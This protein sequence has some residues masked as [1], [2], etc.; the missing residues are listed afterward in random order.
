MSPSS[1]I[2]IAV[3]L[4]LSGPGVRVFRERRFFDRGP[5]FA[6]VGACVQAKL[7]LSDEFIFR[8]A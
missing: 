8:L 7:S 1:Q 4:A 3:N 6:G 2:N 5:P